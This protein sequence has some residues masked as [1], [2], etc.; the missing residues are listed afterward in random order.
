LGP[1][2]GP[3]FCPCPRA[4]ATTGTL[5]QAMRFSPSGR[6]S[7]PPSPEAGGPYWGCRVHPRWPPFC[8]PNPIRE[9]RRNAAGNLCVV[10]QVERR[11]RRS[12]MRPP[13]IGIAERTKEI[14]WRH[15]WLKSVLIDAGKPFPMR[16]PRPKAIRPLTPRRRLER[17]RRMRGALEPQ[18]S[19]M[20][21]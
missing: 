7:V 8:E 4:T 13:E 19:W 15:V 1:K 21:R 18:R 3:S 2:L 12:A 11:T 20:A 16:F 10:R 17:L 14:A 5:L 6:Q 9:A